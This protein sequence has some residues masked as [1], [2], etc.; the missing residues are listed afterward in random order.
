MML[1]VEGLSRVGQRLAAV[2]GAAPRV[3]AQVLYRSAEEIMTAAKLLTPVDS[4]ALRG[5]GH[6]LPPTSDGATMSVELGF[7]GVAGS[8]NQ[9]ETNSEDVGYAL[10]VHENPV[11]QHPVGQWKYLEVPVRA[12]I[13]TTTQQEAA[14]IERAFVMETAAYQRGES[15]NVTG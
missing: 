10:L 6:V 9:G 1:I 13:Q 15:V 7:G 14:A 5:S 3:S 12:A 2:R 11:A 8:G 4:G